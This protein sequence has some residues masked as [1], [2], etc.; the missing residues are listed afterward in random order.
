MTYEVQRKWAD[1]YNSQLNQVAANII[2]SDP[3]L[4][5]VYFKTPTLNED[6]KLGIDCWIDVE[7]TKLSYRIREA[8]YKEY[9][10]NGFTVR[11]TAK[12][13]ESE[14]KKLMRDDYADFLLYAVAHPDNYGEV[15]MAVLLDLKLAGA[16]L[17]RFPY[18]TEN[19]T[20]G[21]GFIEFKYDAFP[22][23][24]V[25]G[26]WNVQKKIEPLVTQALNKEGVCPQ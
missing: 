13:G 20:K 12:F 25:V 7:R 14:L 11:T 1:Q 17:Q 9:F 5:S 23:P 24:I 6:R 21:N 18:I 8:K 4:M 10:F 3:K 16:Q 2:F 26:L 15:D 19:A 22:I